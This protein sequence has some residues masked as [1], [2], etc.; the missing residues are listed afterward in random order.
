MHPPACNTTAGSRAR[1]CVYVDRMEDSLFIT[2]QIHY[3]QS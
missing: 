3:S 2:S 1:G